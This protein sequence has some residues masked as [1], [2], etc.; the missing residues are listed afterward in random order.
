MEAEMKRWRLCL[1]AVAVGAA[2]ALGGCGV[3]T[4]S[5]DAKNEPRTD[6]VSKTLDEAE[7]SNDEAA[8]GEEAGEHKIGRAHV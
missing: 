6:T 2:I 5:Q 3:P 7:N 1:L 4:A 8:P